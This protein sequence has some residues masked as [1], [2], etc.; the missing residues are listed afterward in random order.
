MTSSETAIRTPF[1]FTVDFEDIGTDMLRGLGIDMS[2]RAREDLLWRTYQDIRGF[3]AEHL[4]GKPLTFFCTGVLGEYAKDVVAQIAADGNEIA[5][6]YHF[7]DPVYRDAPEVVEER[8]RTAIEL[9]ERA[10]GTEVVGFRAPM[11]SILAEHRGQYQ[12]VAERFRYDSSLIAGLD[13]PFNEADHHEITGQGRMRLF[14]VPKV[15]RMGLVNHKAG[16]TFFKF[17]PVSWSAGALQGAYERG[18]PAVFYIHPYEFCTDGRFMLRHEQLRSLGPVRQTY[19]W[20]RQLQWHRVGNGWVPDKLAELCA[21]FAHQ[22]NMRDLL[23][24]TAA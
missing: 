3:A 24:E 12:K 5:C 9:L 19:W 23:V 22:G 15:R 18:L 13:T 16:G 8:L 14:P 11:F 21:R 20:A 7:H 1:Y 2:A 4:D 17:F 6:H 10:S